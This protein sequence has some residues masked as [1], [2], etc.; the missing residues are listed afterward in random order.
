[1]NKVNKNLYFIDVNTNIARCL[2][3]IVSKQLAISRYSGIRQVCS[4]ILLSFDSVR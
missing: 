4:Y 2:C 3:M 1:M